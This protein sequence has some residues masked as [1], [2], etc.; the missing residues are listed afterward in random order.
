[1]SRQPIPIDPF[2]VQPYSLWGT[3]WLL[4]S[5][6][7]YASGQFNC[8]VV[9][10]GS[11]GRMWSLPFAQVVVRPQRH[12]Y[13][14]MEQH[15]TFTLCAFGEQFHD[16]LGI[17]GNK[18]GR[19]SN[20]LVESGLTPQPA[21]VVGAPVYAEAELAIECRKMYWQDMDPAHMLYPEIQPRHYKTFDF[22]RI[23]W[24]EILAVSGTERYKS[25]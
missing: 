8:M 24:G 4:L 12:T 25:A 23:Y 22:H 10:W 2:L 5:A 9:G 18:S 6:G 21:S 3:Q 17:L 14:F 11:L 15:G 7:D 16:A 20:K 19:D 1:M 13:Q